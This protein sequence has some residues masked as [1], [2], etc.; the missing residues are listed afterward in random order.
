MEHEAEGKLT[1]WHVCQ[2][3]P[4]RSPTF[5]LHASLALAE[6]E[7]HCEFASS[8]MALQAGASAGSLLVAP[9]LW[10]GARHPAAAT[11]AL[12]EDGHGMSTS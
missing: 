7:A 1:C 2:Q 8:Y 11:L 4:N 9:P 12:A 5:L 10:G 6:Y 3:P